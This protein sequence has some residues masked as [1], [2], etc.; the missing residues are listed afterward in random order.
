VVSG[1]RLAGVKLPPA[2]KTARRVEWDML[3]PPMRDRIETRLGSKVVS[4]ATATGGFTPGFAAVLTCADGS[5]HFVKA[6]S[7]VA[8][9][10]FADSYRAE[11]RKLGALPAGV[12]A[13]RLLWSLDEDW[14]ALELEYVDG[15]LPSRPWKPADLEACLDT[16]ETVATVLTPPPAGLELDT[17]AE[18]FGP[19]LTGWDYVRSALP[20]LPHLA[21]A[22]ALAARFGELGGTTL[23]HTDIRDDNLLITD[24][25]L[26]W[27]CDWN[28][29]VVGAGWIDTVCLLIQAY[30]DGHD[31]DAILATRPLT[32]K[33][34][35]ELI[36][37]LLA[38]LAGFFFRQRDEPGPNSSPYLRMHQNWYAEATWAWL[39][40]RRGWA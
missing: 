6:A 39:A 28:W 11:I 14:V 24:T 2:G 37:V 13:A 33:V 27:I 40:E 10:V 20:D 30:G 4:A 23:V 16:L 19:F 21:E 38:L 36:D 34:D 29:P 25:G 17:F 3:P 18:E 26:V 35:G 7:N 31:A 1:P 15:R 32:R 9:K 5:R 8:Q 22:A 12:P